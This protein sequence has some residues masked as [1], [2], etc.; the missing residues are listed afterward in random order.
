MLLHCL[1]PENPVLPTVVVITIPVILPGDK[2]VTTEGYGRA[3][4][5]WLRDLE[6]PDWRT[7]VLTKLIGPV[8]DA[9][10]PRAGL[11]D[12][13]FFVGHGHEDTP[14]VGSAAVL[15]CSTDA[16]ATYGALAQELAQWYWDRR[17]DFTY[18][19]DSPTVPWNEA[20]Q[21][22]YVAFDRGQKVLFGDLGDNANAGTSGDVPFVCR[23]LL[24]HTSSPRG[25]GK[26]HPR[27]LIAGLADSAA[28]SACAEALAKAGSSNSVVLSRLTIGAGHAVGANFG[29]G[30]EPLELRGACIR[31][32]VNNGQWAIVD[33]SPNVTVVLQKSAWAFFSQADVAR[34][35]EAFHPSKYDVVVV[36][37][38]NV[39]SLA[40]PM[41]PP[42]CPLEEA[43]KTYCIMSTTPGANC[44]PMRPRP[45]LR[46][47][48]YPECPE[49]D[50]TAPLGMVPPRYEPQPER[51]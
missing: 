19:S 31:A 28:V 21:E 30:C 17:A 13:S 47:G 32:M 3:L 9:V 8:N 29:E 36:K 5:R 2:V 16:A 22:L 49:R 37:R 1:K 45:R 14:R 48:M 33:A 7:P 34:L 41:L 15:T 38:G 40:E 18:P 27:V 35:S 26:S 20:V 43:A 23:R 42:G 50:W 46:P 4:Y 44:Y 24:E 39:A 6:P 25:G 51:A 11:L 12:A 10:K